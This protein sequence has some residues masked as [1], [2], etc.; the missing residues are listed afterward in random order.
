MNR[1]RNDPIVCCRDFRGRHIGQIAVVYGAGFG[2]QHHRGCVPQK[3]GDLV[4]RGEGGH[5]IPVLNLQRNRTVQG[6]SLL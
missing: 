4:E 1:I 6:L 2:Q 3:L 5:A